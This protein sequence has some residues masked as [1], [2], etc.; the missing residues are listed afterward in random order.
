M[1]RSMRTVRAG[2]TVTYGVLNGLAFFNPRQPPPGANIDHGQIDPTSEHPLPIILL[3]G[4]TATQGT[5]WGVGAPVLANAGYRVYTF[6][7]GNVTGNPNSPI[8][9]TADISDVRP[10]VGR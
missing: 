6:N 10:G 4:T 1:R 5:N 9:A 3:N 7:Y 2:F 8:Q